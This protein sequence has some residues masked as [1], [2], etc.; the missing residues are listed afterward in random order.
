MIYQSSRDLSMTKTDNDLPETHIG[1]WAVWRSPW[2]RGESWPSW[3]SPPGR[4]PSSRGPRLSVWP[5]ARTSSHSGL[6]QS[7]TEERVSEGL[8]WTWWGP[9]GWSAWVS[10]PPTTRRAWPGG[11]TPR[12][13]RRG[14]ALGH[15]REDPSH[16]VSPLSGVQLERRVEEMFYSVNVRSVKIWTAELEVKFIS[17]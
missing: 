8:D 16:R 10:C 14:G 13:G 15:W 11:G 4:S 12:R 1:H 17:W 6:E 5:P 2:R 9:S 3:C 7:E